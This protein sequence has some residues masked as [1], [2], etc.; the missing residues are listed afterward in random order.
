[1]VLHL[2]VP[3]PQSYTFCRWARCKHLLQILQDIVTRFCRWQ[4]FQS[5][6]DKGRWKCMNS[7]SLCE[8]W[9]YKY[10]WDQDVFI[11]NSNSF[12]YICLQKLVISAY[13]TLLN[14]CMHYCLKSSSITGQ[15]S[16]TIYIH[17]TPV[18]LLQCSVK[19]CGYF[20]TMKM[21]HAML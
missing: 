13:I 7:Q 4:N 12:L 2:L 10:E 17:C 1:M 18:D 3:I 11:I 9:C 20:K 6:T 8:H 19:M 21:V 5:L 16:I 14:W 15:M